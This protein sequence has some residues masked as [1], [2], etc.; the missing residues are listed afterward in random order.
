MDLHTR[1]Q[2]HM[3]LIFALLIVPWIVIYTQCHTTALLLV[4]W[5]HTQGHPAAL[6]SKKW[7]SVEGQKTVWFIQN[8]SG[9]LPSLKEG[10]AAL[11]LV[12]FCADLRLD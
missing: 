1:D 9:T 10:G 5:I 6:G 12:I 2:L 7:L 4:P 3:Y 8:Y 11:L